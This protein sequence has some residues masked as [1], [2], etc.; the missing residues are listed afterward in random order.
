MHSMLSVSLLALL[1]SMLA[2]Y[3]RT[4]LL[5]ISPLKKLLHVIDEG[6]DVVM[7]KTFN[8]VADDEVGRLV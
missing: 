7:P 6:S 3:Y 5:V 4:E 8:Y 1:L 2:I